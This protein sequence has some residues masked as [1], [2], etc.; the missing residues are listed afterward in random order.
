MKNK[1]IYGGNG[2]KKLANLTLIGIDETKFD[3]EYSY[4]GI[5]RYASWEKD[6]F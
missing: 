1:D 3:F 5:S 6:D 4:I 2:F